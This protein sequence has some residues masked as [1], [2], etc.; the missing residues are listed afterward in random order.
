MK[1]KILPKGAILL[2]LVLFG[3]QLSCGGPR[4]GETADTLYKVTEG[5]DIYYD[6]K[7][8]EEKYFL[9]YVLS[10][11]SGLSFV[12]ENKVA[13]IEDEGGRV[14]IYDFK[15]KKIVHSIRFS[16][17]GDFEGVEY[18]NGEYF[19]LES[20]GD[21]YRFDHTDKKEIE[22]KKIETVLSRDNDTEGLGYDPKSGNLLI[23]CKDNGDTK[24][25]KVKGKAVYAFNL[26]SEK[27]IKSVRFEIWSKDIKEF[28]EANKDFQY[29]ENKIKFEPSAIAYHPIHDAYYVLASRGKMLLVLNENGSIIAS[30]PIAPQILSQPEG[31]AFSPNGDMYISSEGEGDRGYII[32]FSMQRR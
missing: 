19:V 13:C 32:R 22:S 10:E 29:E 23:A 3:I 25:D 7:K 24:V 16:N 12:D 18:V 17:A 31:I 2:F 6:L 14:F 15:E 28:L 27:I 30:Y 1:Y 4:I 26:N 11:I 20:D 21:I 8:P 9:P 5:V